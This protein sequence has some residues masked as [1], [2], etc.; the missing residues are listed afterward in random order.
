MPKSKFTIWLRTWNPRWFVN[1]FYS[2]SV[3]W[4]LWWDKVVMDFLDGF[5]GGYAEVVRSEEGDEQ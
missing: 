2:P 4:I 3:A 5:D 1:P